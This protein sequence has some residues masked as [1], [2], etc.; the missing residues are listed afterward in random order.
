MKPVNKRNSSYIDR[1]KS[2]DAPTSVDRPKQTIVV[3][4]IGGHQQPMNFNSGRRN[5]RA[6]SK[7]EMESILGV[8][9]MKHIRDRKMSEEQNSRNPDSGLILPKTT[10]NIITAKADSIQSPNSMI[11][12]NKFKHF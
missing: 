7:F 2:V 10:N 9:E 3:T 11:K 12:M 8:S 5:S 4:N 6:L 1:N